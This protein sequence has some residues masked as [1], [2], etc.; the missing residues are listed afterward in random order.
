[1]NDTYGFGRIAEGSTPCRRIVSR[2]SCGR[3]AKRD[4]EAGGAFRRGMVVAKS[5]MMAFEKGARQRLECGVSELS[6]EQSRFRRWWLK[7]AK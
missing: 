6:V 1:M 2:S 5:G 7:Q 4:R 3:D